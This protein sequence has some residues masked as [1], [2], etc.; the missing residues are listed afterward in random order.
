MGSPLI[1][2]AL[3]DPRKNEKEAHFATRILVATMPLLYTADMPEL[4]AWRIGPV[5]GVRDVKK[6]VAYYTD[7]LGFE[8]QG[9]IFEGA[10]PGEGGVYAVVRRQEIEIHLQIR[11]RDIYAGAREDIESDTYVFVQDADA[12]CQEFQAKG[13][14]ILRGVQDEPYG[15][16]DFVV[17]DPEGHRLV[18]GAPLG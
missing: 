3:R 12:L 4:P 10:A 14:V 15:L 1:G 6:A 8:C 16:R 11:R 13:A 17:E 18:F 7:I 2:V 5:L 9:G